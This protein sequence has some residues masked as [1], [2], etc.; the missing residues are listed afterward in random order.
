MRAPQDAEAVPRTFFT[1]WLVAAL[2]ATMRTWP[3][4][5]AADTP[6]AALRKLVAVKPM[7]KL[8]LPA[9]PWHL[10]QLLEMIDQTSA[11]VGVGRT[12]LPVESQ[13]SLPLQTPHTPPQPSSPHVRPVHC[14]SQAQRPAALQDRP[15]VQVPHDPP[16]PFGP[17]CLP[18]QSGAHWQEPSMQ[19][20]PMTQAPQEPPQPSLPHVLP[21]Q[22]GVQFDTQI[23]R[24]SLHCW[25]PGQLPQVPPQPSSPQAFPSQSG[26]QRQAPSTQASPNPQ[27]PQVPPHPS[28]PQIRSPQ[29]G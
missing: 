8:P 20:F 15:S 22:L 1:R 16:Q 19:V 6:I 26:S 12:Q 5:P 3:A 24:S 13:M 7:V 17:H 25:P 18:R 27:L 11:I 9:E 28:S 10:V 4:Q 21:S 29:S 2:P 23:P 14:D